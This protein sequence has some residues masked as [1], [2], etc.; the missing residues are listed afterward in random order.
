M[1]QPADVV[2]IVVDPELA[3]DGRSQASGR[4][5]V[6]RKTV[7][8]GTRE[9]HLA[10]TI[11]LI[12]FSSFW[13]GFD[14]ADPWRAQASLKSRRGPKKAIVAIAA[15]LL[16]A[17]YFILKRVV[18]YHELGGDFYDRMDST[19]ATASL[20]RRLKNLGYEVS[21]SPVT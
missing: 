16:R 1:H 21:L 11:H 9:I 3:L 18:P 17:A 20:V 19:K 15:D 5:A 2:L 8:G 4:P 12:R 7:R 14:Y 13:K 6:A 10:D